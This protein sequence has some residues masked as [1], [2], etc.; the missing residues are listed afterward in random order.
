MAKITNREK[1]LTAL[2]ESASVI[3]AAE[4]CGLS[5]ETL[6]RYLRDKDFLKEYRDTRRA[7]VENAVSQLQQATSE[8]V[9]T[10]KENLHC[11]NPAIAVRASQ[12]ILDFAFKGLE[13]TDILERLEGLENAI[14]TEA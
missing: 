12:I 1:A 5:K 7:T 11:E 3:E 6:F 8:A 4:K 9:Q 14:K 13:T 10:L 2:I